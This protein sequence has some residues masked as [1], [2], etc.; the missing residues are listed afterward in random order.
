MAGT[1]HPLEG[2]PIYGKGK[3]GQDHARLSA[4]RAELKQ[5]F[6]GEKIRLQRVIR[7]MQGISGIPFGMLSVCADGK[8]VQIQNV[9]REGF[10]FRTAEELPG[11]DT[12]SLNFYDLNQAAYQNV[13]LSQGA[14]RIETAKKKPYWQE[15][16]V[17]VKDL[18]Y[19]EEIQKLVLGYGRYI[20]LKLEEDDG[21]LTQVMTGYPAWKDE[22]YSESLEEQ[23]EKWFAEEKKRW[24]QRSIERQNRRGKCGRHWRWL[25]SWTGR[26]CMMRIYQKESEIL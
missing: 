8:E 26:N 13:D 18:T 4:W 7:G 1:G 20:R 22:I 12:F 17:F 21:E 23:K 5:P 14:F 16:R 19:K 3:S 15:Y 11:V 9:S 6:T 2:D 10:I 24:K 25:W